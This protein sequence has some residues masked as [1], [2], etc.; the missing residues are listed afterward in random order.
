MS[1]TGVWM[2]KVSVFGALLIGLSVV[3]LGCELVTGDV[4]HDFAGAG[5]TMHAAAGE[6][7]ESSSHGGSA[8]AGGPEGGASG[9]GASGEGGTG[10][11][12]E[13]AGAAGDSGAAGTPGGCTPLNDDNPCTDDVCVNGVPANPPSAVGSACMNGGTLCDGAG[14]CVACL[15]ASDCAGTDNACQTRTC[16]H[17]TCGF[18]FAASG[19]LLPTQTA[20]DCKQARCDGAGAISQV[21]D[22][23]DVPNDS[24]LCTSDVCNGGT[25]SNL[26]KP[27]G[28]TCGSNL[29][30]S[31]SAVC[32]GCNTAAD[33]GSSD[34]CKTR[35]CVSNQCGVTFTTSGTALA[36]Q[37]AG[38]C[39]K[40]TC[41]GSGNV[42]NLA[43]STDL[44]ADD[45]NACTDE[46]CA[47]G[48]PQHPAKSNGAACSDGNGCTTGDTC[49]SGTCSS[50]AA[51]TCTALDQCHSAG[52][53][54]SSTGLCSNPLKAPGAT[55]TQNG[56]SVCSAAGAC[57]QCLA[58]S[59]CPGTDTECHTRTC[60]NNQCGVSNTLAVT[61]TSAQTAGD[62]ARN[63]CDG[64]GN[65][66]SVADNTDVPAD[67]GNQCTSET[68]SAGTPVHPPKAAD[69]ACNQDGG[70]FCNATSSCVACNAPAQCP[71]ADTACQTRTC[72][73]NA[74]GVDKVAGGTPIVAQTVGDCRQ[75]QCDGGGNIVPVVDDTDVPAD[76]GNECT[77]EVCSGGVAS[78]PMV[79]PGT[80]CDQNG[81]HVCDS[82]GACSG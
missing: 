56:G 73:G 8:V 27:V 59:D 11:A 19:T 32:V 12:R 65:I 22:D 58:A 1:R 37:T 51:V 41:D 63:Q 26:P 43:D 30:C 76:D 75:N 42:T 82:S 39:L 47:Q 62:C 49:Q 69:T 55:C 35:T 44:P 2:S 24:N 38:N 28:T 23:A 57:V 72:S 54:S 4:S 66:V 64:S 13:S 61:P 14:A 74:C 45:G 7:G 50:G 67:D 21:T 70:S 40:A 29:L 60:T 33:C 5:G 10:G 52:T 34:E 15:A 79:M 81:G 48:V 6:A 80:T 9:A 16:S 77:A 18:D 78:H 17:G 3:P 46:A 20:G 71:G 36:A 25:P 53:C 31:S 68:C